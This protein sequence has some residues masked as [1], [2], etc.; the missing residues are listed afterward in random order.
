MLQSRRGQGSKSGIG[1]RRQVGELIA[2]RKDA[3]RNAQS[4]ET[5]QAET[6]RSKAGNLQSASGIRSVFCPFRPTSLHREH[7]MT[8]RSVGV[9][10]ILKRPSRH[11]AA[12]RKL[13]FESMSEMAILRQLSCRQ[14]SPF[15][16]RNRRIP[17][18]VMR[19]PAVEAITRRTREE[20]FCDSRP[21]ER[22]A[23]STQIPHHNRPM[24]CI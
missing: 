13:C 2:A 6:N 16:G 8:A 10:G 4:G 18:I 24:N 12:L 15:V 3:R 7:P 9:A 11:S 19:Q 21:R 17:I 22:I 23:A 1:A 14:I 20:M 5:L